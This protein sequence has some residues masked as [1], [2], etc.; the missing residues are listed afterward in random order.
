MA[1]PRCVAVPSRD[2]YVLANAHVPTGCIEGGASSIAGGGASLCVDVDN[3][4]AVDIV[5]RGGQ[6]AALYPAG[7]ARQHTRARQVD[8]AG[9]MVLP[10]FADLHTHIGGRGRH[11]YGAAGCVALP[12]ASLIL[13][14]CT[15]LPPGCTSSLLPKQFSTSACHRTFL[16]STA[17]KGHTTER[18]RN[19]NGSLSGA[20]RSTAR[21]AAFWDEADVRRRMDFSLRCAYAYGTSALRTH[22]INMTPKQTQLTWP[23][24]SQLRKQWAGKVRRLAGW[25]VGWLAGCGWLAG[26]VRLVPGLGWPATCAAWVAA[27]GQHHSS[28]SP[29][30]PPPPV[31]LPLLLCPAG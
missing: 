20:D 25:L 2:H 15:L 17:D 31:H 9:K 29:P 24:Y 1:A 28:P 8:L 6:V 22:L 4:A 5:V 14:P 26:W 7:S 3:L 18:S 30:S 27:A 11:A 12:Q 16:F 21:D 19:P 13:P 10:T 23:V